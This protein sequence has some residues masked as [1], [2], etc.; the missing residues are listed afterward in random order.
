[1]KTNI[2]VK[3]F[4]KF[5]FVMEEKSQ[6]FHKQKIYRYSENKKLFYIVTPNN[7]N[8]NNIKT[9]DEISVLI[10]NG[11]M[12][13]YTKSNKIFEKINLAWENWN[14]Q[15]EHNGKTFFVS[16]NTDLIDA[17][18]HYGQMPVAKIG[19]YHGELVWVTEFQHIPRVC[20]CRF[21]D[22]NE[23][24]NWEYSG[25]TNIRNIKPVFCQETNS[26]I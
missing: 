5:P 22:I 2:K 6:S 12:I 25:Y 8:N 1:M 21:N 19:Y 13:Q 26:Y 18:W 4:E 15:W 11:K 9:V 10:K 7:D 24:P 3:P 17:P 23:A 16:A 14:D 20:F